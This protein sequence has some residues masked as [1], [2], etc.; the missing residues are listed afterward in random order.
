M[1]D[2]ELTNLRAREAAGSTD[3]VD[4]LV[5]LAAERGDLDELRR[6]AASGSTDAADVLTERSED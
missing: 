3:A 6:L 2:Q 1:G 4:E 5:E